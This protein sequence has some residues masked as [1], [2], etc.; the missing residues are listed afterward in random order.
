MHQIRRTMRP[1][2]AQKVPHQTIAQ[3]IDTI[4]PEE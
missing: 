1:P 2:L 3:I 4:T